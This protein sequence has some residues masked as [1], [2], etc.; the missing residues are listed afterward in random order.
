[1]HSSNSHATLSGCHSLTAFGGC[2]LRRTNEIT[3]MF[4]QS[5][6]T[7]KKIWKL[8]DNYHKNYH[9][10]IRYIPNNWTNDFP[11]F[12]TSSKY[13]NMGKNLSQLKIIW[14]NIEEVMIST[15]FRDIDPTP[16]NDVKNADKRNKIT[17]LDLSL[18]VVNPQ[19]QGGKTSLRNY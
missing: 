11:Q 16:D 8:S 17:D 13:N 10:L 14:A 7:K 19:S 5:D 3:T 2:S 1:M 12:D 6:S 4:C 18:E 15:K 9:H